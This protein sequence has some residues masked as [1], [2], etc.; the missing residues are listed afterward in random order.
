MSK[1]TPDVSE[2]YLDC[3]SFL[4]KVPC[5]PRVRFLF[6]CVFTASINADI[7]F[8]SPGLSPT[9][10]QIRQNACRDAD[11]RSARLAPSA[12][13]V[14]LISA[15]FIPPPVWVQ[16]LRL[17]SP[18]I[19]QPFWVLKLSQGIVTW[20]SRSAWWFGSVGNFPLDINL[21][22]ATL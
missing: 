5:F 20:V 6:A 8:R 21:A 10:L 18:S 22:V 1:R 14:D 3:Q 13:R 4:L 15:E 17:S 2:K 9:K 12:V 7:C 16:R 11:Q 19:S